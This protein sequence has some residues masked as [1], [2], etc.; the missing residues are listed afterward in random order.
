MAR[1][2]FVTGTDTGV[3]KT[4]IA[5]ALIKA[6]QARGI[7]ACGMKPVE[8]GCR[9][10]DGILHPADGMFLKKAAKM[11]EDIS[12]ITPFCFETPAAPLAASEREG[13]AV[14]I[15]TIIDKFNALLKTYGSVVVEGIGGIL[16]PI[17]RDY[18]VIDLIKELG[19]P[20]LVVT[21]PSIGTINHT[22]LT[23][24]YA[25]KE[26]IRVS[27]IITNFSRASENTIAEQTSLGMLKQL[28]PVPTIL[29][30]PYLSDLTYK[31]LEAAALKHLDTRILLKQTRGVTDRL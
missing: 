31:T 8:T 12:Q 2:F 1:G 26:G 27:G 30:F 16:V 18:F 23:V 17:K 6:L 4:V 22:L 29:A 13:R 20:V 19:L 7:N 9:R 11:N 5:G 25:L 24:K 21:K 28:S 15:S 10:I 3:G 14:D